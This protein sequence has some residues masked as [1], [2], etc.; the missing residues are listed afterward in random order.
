MNEIVEIQH[1]TDRKNHFTV[2]LMIDAT[3]NCCA[4]GFAGYKKSTE[5][6]NDRE[7]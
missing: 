1:V 3:E 2:T 6:R 7:K 4:Y 5:Q